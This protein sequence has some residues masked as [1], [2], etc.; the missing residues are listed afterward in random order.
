MICVWNIN[1][2]DI[3]IIESINDNIMKLMKKW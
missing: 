2:N 1:D 3:N